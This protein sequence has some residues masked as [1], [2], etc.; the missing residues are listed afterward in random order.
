MKNSLTILSFIAVLAALTSCSSNDPMKQ[1]VSKSYLTELNIPGDIEDRIQYSDD[2]TISQIDVYYQGKLLRTNKFQWN[3]DRSLIVYSYSPAG[4]LTESRKI[5]FSGG[6][7]S[8]IDV[9]MA[10]SALGP[11]SNSTFTFYLTQQKQLSYYTDVQELYNYPKVVERGDVTWKSDGLDLIIRDNS[12]AQTGVYSLHTAGTTDSSPWLKLKPEIMGTTSIDQLHVIH[13]F[14]SNTITSM[15]AYTYD[16]QVNDAT[17][18]VLSIRRTSVS[19]GTIDF[20]KFNWKVVA[21]K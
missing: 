20:F 15:G 17:G 10:G 4:A 13:F 5:S 18:N 19:N 14:V 3:T 9:S 7:I 16:Q 12:G 21:G 1:T 6:W 11:S 8:G 2:T